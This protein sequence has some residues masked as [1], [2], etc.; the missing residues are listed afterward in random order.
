MQ[1][2]TIK[3]GNPNL[4]ALTFPCSIAS[5][6]SLSPTTQL[7]FASAY[8]T[9]LLIYCVSLDPSYSNSEIKI[10]G[11]LEPVYSQNVVSFT[12]CLSG[13]LN[14]ATN[15]SFINLLTDNASFLPIFYSSIIPPINFYIL[16]GF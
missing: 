10:S 4:G 3:Y 9:K 1:L 14:C 13:I 6:H 12:I 5:F 11:L 15:T 7:S 8:A 16:L 2:V